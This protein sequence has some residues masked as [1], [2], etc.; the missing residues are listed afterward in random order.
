MRTAL[1]CMSILATGCGPVQPA[2]AGATSFSGPLPVATAAID[3]PAQPRA[4]A[5][6]RPPSTL[7][8]GWRPDRG[9]AATY[10]AAAIKLSSA[11]GCGPVMADW[12]E[13]T[14]LDRGS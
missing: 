5:A 14:V 2:L 13:L 6:A 8:L 9:A 12:L 10:A 11:E 4:M 3:R 7:D 1:I